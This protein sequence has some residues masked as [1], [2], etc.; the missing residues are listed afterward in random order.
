[1]TNSR[2]TLQ[3]KG[4]WRPRDY[5]YHVLC[6]GEDV[7]NARQSVE[8]QHPDY[9]CPNPNGIEIAL[10]AET[11]AEAKQLVGRILQHCSSALPKEQSHCGLLNFTA[12][13]LDQDLPNRRF[14]EIHWLCTSAGSAA[15]CEHL[16]GLADIIHIHHFTQARPLIY[17]RFRNYQWRNQR[18]LAAFWASLYLA[19]EIRSIP[20]L[21]WDSYAS[22]SPGPTIGQTATG[23]GITP[24]D[25][26]ASLLAD[27]QPAMCS[28]ALHTLL[29]IE[30]N[31]DLT[32]G[33]YVSVQEQLGEVIECELITTGWQ[34]ANSSGF[35]LK[36]LVCVAA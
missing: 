30:A 14:E 28:D 34:T 25:S 5:L 8:H 31:F 6:Q 10:I 3:Q 12:L 18:E 21:N 9:R 4:G 20:G 27:T 35:G 29:V 19:Q 13:G 15:P 32:L 26:V 22:W 16:S 11:E 24:T 33:D 23:W 17:P 2:R 36:L 7:E 1:M